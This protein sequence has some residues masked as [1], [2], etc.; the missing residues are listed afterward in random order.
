[1]YNHR[2]RYSAGQRSQVNTNL[3]VTTQHSD[4]R[5]KPSFRYSDFPLSNCLPVPSEK[6]LDTHHRYTYHVLYFEKS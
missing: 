1:M 2:T 6:Y 3:L 4:S 5:V